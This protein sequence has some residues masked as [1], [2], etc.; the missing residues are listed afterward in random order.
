MSESSAL[1]RLLRLIREDP[2][3]AILLHE[4][5]GAPPGLRPMDQ[6]RP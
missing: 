1:G 4:I 3:S 6:D 2:R 5:L